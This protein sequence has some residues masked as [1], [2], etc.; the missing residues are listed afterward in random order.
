MGSIR[1]TNFIVMLVLLLIVAVFAFSYNTS[2]SMA[3][4]NAAIS[5]R[6]ILHNYNI[7]IISSLAQCESEEQW[8]DV[9][10]RYEDIVV[11]IENSE[12]ETVAETKQKENSSSFDVKVQNVF[13]FK[14]R[15]YILTSSV[16]IL[17][18]YISDS[19][20][21]LKF[22]FIEFMI[23]IFFLFF[24]FLIIYTIMLRPYKAFYVSIEEYEKTGVL[25]K[26]NFKG[27]I[28]RVYERFAEMTEN[29]ERQQKS[30][31]QIIAS[32]SHDIKTPLT[33]IMGYAERLKKDGIPEERRL[34]YLE[35]VYNKSAEIRQLVDKFDEYLSFELEQDFKTEKTQTEEICEFIKN[36]YAEEL[37]ASEITF[38]I[39]NSA[40]NVSCLIDMQK[41]K[42]VFANIIS[43]SVKH[44]NSEVKIIS[45]ELTQED[46]VLKIRISDSGEGVEKDKLKLIFEP[47]YTSDKGR[48]VAGLGL[49]ICREII[50]KHGGNISA[51][52]SSLG[53]LEICIE[54]KII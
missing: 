13:E 17:K 38:E 31:R 8:Q 3:L 4:E 37:E 24:L 14:G 5:N 18:N 11:I 52:A 50:E 19:S 32:I 42:R 48:K 2:V 25:R 10:D 28:G 15:A 26:N 30:Q 44:F 16:F 45:V 53:G 20:E 29:L 33:S 40:K 34:R 1:K 21:I 35:T 27:Y 41:F 6:E 54:L 46:K 36:E 39:I 9:V 7:E 49:A 23:F 22:V 51:S 47:L 12:N 43:N